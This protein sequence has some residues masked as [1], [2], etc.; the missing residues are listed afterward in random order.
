MSRKMNARI[1]AKDFE[2]YPGVYVTKKYNILNK[3]LKPE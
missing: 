3:R 1:N 2:N